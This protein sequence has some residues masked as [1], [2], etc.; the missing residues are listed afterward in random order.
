MCVSSN[1][2]TIQILCIHAETGF[3]QSLRKKRKQIGENV[4]V[5]NDIHDGRIYQ[6]LCFVN[7]ALA[8]DTNISLTL[9]TDGVQ[10]YQSTNYTMWPVLL[11]INELPFAMR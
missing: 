4:D 6:S 1:C 8:E 11:M 10:V 2:M 3:F 9:N 7:D 5:L